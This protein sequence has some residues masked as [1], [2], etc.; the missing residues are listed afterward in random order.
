MVTSAS[1]PPPRVV[2]V[3]GGY[4]ALFLVRALRGAVRR[5]EIDL[6]IISRTNFH[7]FHGFVG[8][9][10]SGR[11]QPQAILSPARRVFHPARFM[12]AEV[13]AIDLEQRQVVISRLLDG[14]E[15]VLD[16]DHLVVSVGVTDDVHGYPGLDE[17]ALLLRDYR[18]A[19][20]T[21]N[22]L[23]QMMEMAA[24]ESDIEDR[25]RLLT[26]VV[27]GGGFGGVEVAT[28]LDEWATRLCADEFRDIDR[29]EVSVVLVHG[30]QRIL[31][32]LQGRHDRLVTWAER[33]IA[34]KTDLRVLTGVRVASATGTDVRLSDGT[35]IP[36]RTIIS[37]T[38][39]AS[40]PLLDQ[41]PFERD[42]RG[43]VVVDATVAVPG[44]QGIWVGGDCAAVPHP[45]GGTCPQ[46]ALFAM[47]HGW[48]IGRNILRL[49]GG[50]D[51]KPF[52]F[53]EL[54]DACSL[55]RRRA[56]AH[57]RGVPVTGFLGWLM[58]K[59]TL[60]AFV[61]VWDRRMRLLLDWAM[62]PFTGR[63]ITQIPLDDAVG[64][65]RERFEAGQ[66]VFRQGEMG[67]KLY[68]I[69]TGAVQVVIDGEVVATLG[70][71]HHFGETAVFEE[72]RRTATI[73]ATEAT[74]LIAMG[75]SN[76]R[77]LSETLQS[78]G[79]VVRARPGAR[80]AAPMAVEESQP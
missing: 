23:L 50:K 33:F 45:R 65:Q 73:R 79:D 16:F 24:I 6:V 20:H 47:M 48:R 17:H 44:T 71:G 35:I 58:W 53:T 52:T 68:L 13:S 43:R 19:W 37:S 27:A 3:G 4:C 60:L 30:G 26:F 29:A 66:E 18:D 51:A 31:P 14:R 2:C 54:G 39:T 22:H 12:N 8:E 72:V 9:M 7:A 75:K 25:R 77:T 56:V 28:E 69:W 62:T 36:T 21:R 38:G 61:P 70:P 5:G 78:F 42:D 41:L 64:I 57:L 11:I 74:E 63:E 34:R 1:P 55:G 59:A 49:Q 10:L 32:E 67:R 80:V 46:L 15:Q 76:A 40:S